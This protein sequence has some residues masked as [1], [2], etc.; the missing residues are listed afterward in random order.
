MPKYNG[1]TCSWQF[2]ARI[3]GISR[4]TIYKRWKEYR[5]RGFPEEEAIARAMAARL[6]KGSGNYKR[7]ERE[8]KRDKDCRKMNKFLS[9]P[10]R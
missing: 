8:T 10:W 6:H 4:Q 2:L 7:Q 9:M 1:K 5:S 3:C